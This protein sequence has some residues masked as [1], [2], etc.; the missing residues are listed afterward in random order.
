MH[1]LHRAARDARP[2]YKELRE[3]VRNAPVVTVD[4]TGWRVGGVGHWLWVAVTP[5]TTVYAICAGRGFDDAQMVLGADF[6]GVLVCGGGDPRFSLQ[7]DSD[8]AADEESNRGIPAGFA[9]G[10]SGAPDDAQSGERAACGCMET[11]SRT[12]YGQKG[13]HCTTCFITSLT[14]RALTSDKAC[15]VESASVVFPAEGRGA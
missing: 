12:E 1:L 3:Q 6:D 5:T 13:T 10:D 9:T 8:C 2:A 7:A 11:D 4:E 15:R 14:G